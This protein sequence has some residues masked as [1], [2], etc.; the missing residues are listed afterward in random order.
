[1]FD[2]VRFGYNITYLDGLKG[3]GMPS[4][5]SILPATARQ[6]R[7]REVLSKRETV[8]IAELAGMFG[9][10]EMTVR[11]DL[12]VLEH[13]GEVRRTHGGAMATERMVF[14][15]DFRARHRAN[16]RAKQAIARKA[17]DLVEPGQTIVL[18]TGTTTLELAHLLK[19]RR[20]ISVIP[21][22]LAVAS[23]LQFSEGIRTV[24]L[25]GVVRRGSPDLTGA[26]TEGN[27][28]MFAADIAFQGA[29]AID[30]HGKLYNADLQIAHVDKKMRQRAKRTYILCDSSKIGRT[31]LACNGELREVDALI[32]DDGIDPQHRHAFEEM[33]ATLIVVRRGN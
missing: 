25:G 28:D 27:L 20:D 15:F 22:S 18:D 29:D 10:S 19:T 13:S 8:S 17:A 30:Q 5:T 7:I 33:G 31:A 12:G 32:T 1:M 14:A 3:F 6:A 11:R 4:N 24:L 23:E 2:S 21:P 26:V 16:R 9:V